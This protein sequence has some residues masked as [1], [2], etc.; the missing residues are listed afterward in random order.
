MDSFTYLHYELILQ[1]ALDAGYNFIGYP[2]FSKNT[3]SDV[4]FCLLRHDC[5]NDLV[6]A[7]VM[8]EIEARRR[9]RSTYFVMTRA[10]LYNLF[11][12]PN[13]DLVR[14]IIGLGHWLG[15]HFDV[16]AYPQ[17]SP[18]QLSA[19]VDREKTWLAEEFGVSVDVVS[20]H[21]PPE[22]VMTNKIKI[23][24]I[25]T[26]DRQLF[27]DVH[28]ISDSNM[29]WMEVPPEQ[30]FLQVL[31]PRLQLLLH[32]EWWTD[33]SFTTD[34]KWR[35]MLEHNFG[36]MQDSLLQRERAYHKKLSLIFR[37]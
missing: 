32:P 33:S 19:L 16:K 23:N 31:Y 10:A 2:E 8:A 30:I 28:Y 11:A 37:E 4:R 15:L 20:F 22:A 7:R 1:N 13:R 17:A 36:L 21:Q 14:E 12:L 3:F 29:I 24:S 26:Y 27:S 9:V 35:V 34:E 6:A 18:D 25:N 5:D